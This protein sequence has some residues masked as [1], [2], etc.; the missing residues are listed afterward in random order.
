[1]SRNRTASSGRRALSAL[2]ALA[3]LT[4]CVGTGSRA[5]AASRAESSV[6]PRSAE[7]PLPSDPTAAASTNPA[8]I[9]APPAL[10]LDA[11]IRSALAH[12][13]ELQRVRTRVDAAEGQAL[14]ARLWPNPEL[15]LTAEDVPVESGGLSQSQNSVGL[16]QTVPF[17][18]K[19]TLNARIGRQGVAVAE[20]ENMSREIELVRDVKIA[21]TTALA[22]EKKAAVSGELLELARSLADATG[23]RVAAGAGTDQERLRADIE[24]D[25][26]QVEL[27]AARRNFLEAQQ[28]LAALIGRAREPL[29][30]LHGELRETAD[31]PTLDQARE[32]ML[33]RHPNLGAALAGQERAE[34]EL[35]RARIDSL[36]D[37]T[38]GVA[39]GRDSGGDE[40]LME[41]R[42]SMP[43]PLFNRSQGRRREARTEVESAGYELTAVEQ[44]LIRELNVAD[45]RLRAAA[46][47]IEAYRTRI[48]PKAEEALRLVRGGFEA[49]KFGFL[50]L[51]DTQRTLAESRLAY[52]E[53]LSELNAAQ[54]E[55]E[56]LVL[57]DLHSPPPLEP[58]HPKHKE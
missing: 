46:E 50:D 19:N 57:K 54:A 4:G 58:S 53:T 10:T 41:F 47:Q 29:G 26:A 11:A 37:V 30:P 44:R 31:L 27:A 40:N 52:Y 33:A 2:C 7:V 25:R 32:Q 28:T 17:P 45:A 20:F 51:V 48:L 18:G 49:G 13:P 22:A 35:R 16:S 55:V 43:L 38:L 1:M 5:P 8:P 6:I 3:L 36:P 24:L 34:L 14:Q 42:V 21:F 39:G 23:K 15:E 56:A 12:N 9:L